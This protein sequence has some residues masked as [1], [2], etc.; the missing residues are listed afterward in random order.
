[1]NIY[2]YSVKK[3]EKQERQKTKYVLAGVMASYLKKDKQK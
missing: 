3:K 2:G 1:M